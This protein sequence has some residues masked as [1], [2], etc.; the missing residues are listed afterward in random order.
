MG[1]LSHD[2]LF[3]SHTKNTHEQ[4]SRGSWRGAAH[5]VTDHNPES[6]NPY[7]TLNQHTLLTQASTVQHE[8][9]IVA[10]LVIIESSF[11]WV[12]WSRSSTVQSNIPLTFRQK[13][14][15]FEYL[16]DTWTRDTWTSK[17]SL[18]SLLIRKMWSLNGQKCAHFELLS[19]VIFC[20]L[21]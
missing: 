5:Q 13:W 2:T 7:F 14:R 11:W 20:W 17:L 9:H 10:S 12:K 1:N 21:L 15:S 6:C 8:F 3:L 4:L 16:R 19:A 18:M